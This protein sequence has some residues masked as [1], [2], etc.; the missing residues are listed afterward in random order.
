MAR[1]RQQFP[2]ILQG[3]GRALRRPTKATDNT[4]PEVRGVNTT[5]NVKRMPTPADQTRG[6]AD[7]MVPAQ[8]SLWEA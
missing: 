5:H 2:R 6:A 7:G 3:V 8:S 4:R 1:S